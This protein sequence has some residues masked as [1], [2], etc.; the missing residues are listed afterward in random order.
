MEVDKED[1]G[2]RGNVNKVALWRKRQISR[3]MYTGD[4][5]SVLMGRT[6][7][8]ADQLYTYNVTNFKVSSQLANLGWLL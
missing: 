2:G 5:V 8:D 3:R 6:V 1:K 4:N 7:S